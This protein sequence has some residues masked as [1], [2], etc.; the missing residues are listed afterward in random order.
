[1][2]P[3]MEGRRLEDRMVHLG[4]A[5]AHE[6]IVVDVVGEMTELL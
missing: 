1:M 5:L 3:A 4:L 6:V 2:G